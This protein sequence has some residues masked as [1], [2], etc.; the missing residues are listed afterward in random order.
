M[1]GFFDAS[2]DEVARLILIRHGRTVSNQEGRILGTTDDPL[3]AHGLLQAEAL[4]ERMTEYGVNA[5]YASPLSRARQTAAAIS[6]C[7][8]VDV[9]IDPDL[10]EY[11]FGELS[12]FTIHALKEQKPVLFEEINVW[13]NMGPVASMPRPVLQNAES[14]AQL[15]TRALRFG[16]KIVTQHQGNVVAA[17]AHAGIIRAMLTLW[18]GGSLENRFPFRSDNASISVVD[19]YHGVPCIRLFNDIT[20][21]KTKLGFGRPVVL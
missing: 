11:D 21:L 1:K 16:E 3:E 4:A 9:Q 2:Q 18:A 14:M 10:I 5:L 13:I 12:D 20:H 6:R 19:F 8:G 17:V 15:A 7:V